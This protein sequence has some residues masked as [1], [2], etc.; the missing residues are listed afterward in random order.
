M[1]GII[2]ASTDIKVNVA[3]HTYDV[4]SIPSD[5]KASKQVLSLSL[6]NSAS[7]LADRATTTNQG[8]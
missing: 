2:T 4:G 7:I 8:G 5:G 6:R 1:S 3:T